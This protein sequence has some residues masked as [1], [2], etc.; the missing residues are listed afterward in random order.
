MKKLIMMVVIA[1]TTLSMN[2][3]KVMVDNV[4]A[5]TT[6]SENLTE[7]IESDDVHSLIGY[8]LEYQAVED[9]FGIGIDF[10]IMHFIISFSMYNLDTNDLIDKNEGWKLGIGYHHRYWFNKYI[11][12]EGSA[13]VQY[14]EHKMEMGGDENSNGEFGLF[15]TPKLGLK[16]FKYCGI[17]AGYRWDFNKFKFSKDYTADY[18]T[19]GLSLA[20]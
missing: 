7:T 18:F 19:V 6:K 1:F 10:S 15:L 4:N 16:L 5:S 2:A 11:Y 12:L 13:G 14:W 17:T 9:G 20:F 8:G 3:Q